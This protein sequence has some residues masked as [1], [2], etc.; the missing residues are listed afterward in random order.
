MMSNGPNSTPLPK[1]FLA[2]IAEELKGLEGDALDQFLREAGED[3]TRLLERSAAA[4]LAARNA[5][6][7]QRLDDARARIKSRRAGDTAILVSFDIAKKRSLLEAIRV[8]G[9]QTG[10]MTMAARNQKIE[11][12]AD[13]DSVLEAC[14]RLG[15]IDERGELKD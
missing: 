8:R 15:V 3:P 9:E 6:G 14:L 7:K 4:Q 12:E 13:L 5:L 1:A 11:S 2:E 10:N